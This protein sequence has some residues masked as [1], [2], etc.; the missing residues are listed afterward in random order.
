MPSARPCGHRWDIGLPF[1]AH[2]YA[3]RGYAVL[4]L[5]PG[6][7]KPH[8][9]LGEQGGVHWATTDPQQIAR[10][11][12]ADPWA[13]I[14]V[15]TG[16]VS[17]LVVVDLDTK[18]DDGRAQFWQFLTQSQLG[19]G[20]D[21]SARTPSGGWH[22]WLRL[23]A[24]M[25]VGRERRA[26]LPGVDVKGDGGYVVAAPSA[27]KM[28]DAAGE[29]PVR[30]SWDGWSCA[31]AAPLAPSW[32]AGWLAHAPASG[33]TGGGDLGPVPDLDEAEVKGF[34]PG[35]RNISFYLAACSMYARGW[36]DHAVIRRLRAIWDKTDQSGMA[37]HE[38]T[39]A[40]A[41]ARAFIERDRTD[42][43]TRTGML[44]AWARKHGG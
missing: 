5:T 29:Y 12:S 40:A 2:Q 8:R 3:G 10:W 18:R 7:K 13:N 26:I 30:Y 11:W 42:E 41:S 9:I 6:S 20:W 15:A 19:M 22:V 33:S 1:A 38:V 23:H 25:P 17:Q 32:M 27:L 14:G 39:T 35:E 21:A 37:W 16:S 31:C 24:G 34:A 43:S 44:A 36:N 4:P 28:S